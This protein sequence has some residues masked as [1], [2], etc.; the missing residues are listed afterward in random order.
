MGHG[1][2]NSQIFNSDIFNTHVSILI[3]GQQSVAQ[4]TKRPELLIPVSFT[5]KLISRLIHRVTIGNF[6]EKLY[7]TGIYT[8]EL[9]ESFILPTGKLRASLK[10]LKKILKKGMY[11]NIFMIILEESSKIDLLRITKELI[12]WKRKQK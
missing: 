9:R 7:P 1:L 8:D 6:R 10:P 3:S 12:K 2:F 4:L 5:F 11:E